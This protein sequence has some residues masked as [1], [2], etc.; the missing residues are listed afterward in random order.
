VK[1]SSTST[2]AATLSSSAPCID[3]VVRKVGSGKQDGSRGGR[4]DQIDDLHHRGK[5][6]RSSCQPQLSNRRITTTFLDLSMIGL[7]FGSPPSACPPSRVATAML[8]TMPSQEKG[9]PKRPWKLLTAP[10]SHSVV[11][12]SSA[13]VPTVAPSLLVCFDSRLGPH[14]P[15]Q[16][17]S[18]LPF[19]VLR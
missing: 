7:R 4:P 17:P 11:R 15:P 14:F 13:G 6:R 10:Q 19:Q 3:S 16:P 12:M 5:S 9:T 18:V 2:H 1:S 8:R